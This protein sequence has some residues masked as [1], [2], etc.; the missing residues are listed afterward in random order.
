M[1]YDV[2]YTTKFKKDVRLLVRRGYDLTKLQSVIERL[3]NNDILPEK[4]Q[5]HAL[6]GEYEGKRE[7]HILPDLLL[8]Y[9][10][11]NNDLKLILIRTG[12]HSDLF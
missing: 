10:I 8:I 5:D 2:F 7:C 3:A 9:R 4:Y 1:K 12:S 6:K 11:N